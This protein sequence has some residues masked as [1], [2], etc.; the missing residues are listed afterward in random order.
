M[1]TKESKPSKSKT[2]D[3]LNACIIR[4]DIPDLNK[5][6]VEVKFGEG[7]KSVKEYININCEGDDKYNHLVLMLQILDLGDSYK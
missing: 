5:N 2:K 6:Q 3:A 1:P 4:F 7:D